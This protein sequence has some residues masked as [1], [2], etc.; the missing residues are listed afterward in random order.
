MTELTRPIR[1]LL[2]RKRDLPDAPP[3]V[4]IELTARTAAPASDTSVTMD[5]PESDFLLAYL[6]TAARPVDLVRLELDSPT[7]RASG[8]GR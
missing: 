5:F 2:G 4:L 1:R 7:V 3:V 8:A 6:Q